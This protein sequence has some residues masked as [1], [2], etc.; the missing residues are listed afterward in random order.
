MLLERYLK[1]I[2]GLVLF[3]SIVLTF[4]YSALNDSSLASLIL[5]SR[6][7]V[8]ILFLVFAWHH[9]RLTKTELLLVSLVLFSCLF[10]TLPGL[11]YSSAY[12]TSRFFNDI[13]GPLLFVFKVSALRS[14]FRQ[15]ITVLSIIKLSKILVILSVIQVLIFLYFSAQTGAYAGITLPINI[16][17]ALYIASFN[18]YGLAV[19]VILITLSGKRSFLVSVAIVSALVIFIRGSHR[20][21]LA[22]LLLLG[23]IASLYFTFGNEKINNTLFALDE[24]FVV[25]EMRQIDF[26]SEQVRSVL[27]LLTAGR[28]EEFYGILSEMRPLSWFIGIGPGFTYSLFH[29]EGYVDGYANAHFSPLSLTYKFGVVYTVV[30]Y[31]YIIGVILSLLKISRNHSFTIG[32]ALSIFILQSMFAF[33]FYAE[34]YFSILLGLGMAIVNAEKNLV[35][36]R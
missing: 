24:F 4:A 21:R 14:L 7:S 26:E 36:T 15:N 32:C 23:F 12:S 30:F 20:K 22:F 35:L 29:V 27:Y 25:T 17:A 34:L 16:P 19:T 10:A 9:I 8:D 6:M 5:V 28:S 3:D 2:F 33:N 11:Q 18:Y 1:V 13:S 31:A